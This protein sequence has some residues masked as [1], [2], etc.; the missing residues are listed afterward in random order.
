MNVYW[1]NVTVNNEINSKLSVLWSEPIPLKKHLGEMYNNFFKENNL[2]H[3]HLLLCPS[4]KEEIKNTFVVFSPIDLTIT[5]DGEITRTHNYDQKFFDQMLSIK[6]KLDGSES[7]LL[8]IN[9]HLIFF[10]EKKCVV[11]VSPAYMSDTDF[12]KNTV[13]MSGQLDLNSW[14]RPLDIT[15]FRDKDKDIII[16]TGD[17]LYYIKFHAGSE[18]KFNRFNFTKELSDVVRSCIGVR[19]YGVASSL[20][21]LYNTF[22]KSMMRGRVLSLI[23]QNLF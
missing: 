21:K 20:S 22:N 13:M 1:A 6:R 17:P 11:T 18:I 19:Q 10:A 23:K 14:F 16:K 12:P 5:W 9:L 15:V 4:I 8:S 7:R 3:T 2:Q